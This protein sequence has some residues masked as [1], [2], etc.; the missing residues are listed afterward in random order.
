MP[1]QEVDAQ[2]ERYNDQVVVDE[3][4]CTVQAG[5]MFG[6]LERNG[7]GKP[8]KVERIEGLRRPDSG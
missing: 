8:T 1:V 4:S 2:V 7:A 6:I 3:V 5:G